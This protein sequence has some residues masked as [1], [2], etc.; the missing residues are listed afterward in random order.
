MTTSTCIL[1][2]GATPLKTLQ[3]TT[4]R[5]AG[6][7][8][9]LVLDFSAIEHID[10]KTL[11]ALDELAVAAEHAKVA[12]AFRGVTVKVYKVFKLAGLTSLFSFVG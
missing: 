1:V 11:R 7:N 3:E 12:V 4:E 6:T 5:L 2:D 9:E 8:G 10:A